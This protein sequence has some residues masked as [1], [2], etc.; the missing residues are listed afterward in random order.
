MAACHCAGM[1]YGPLDPSRIIRGPATAILVERGTD[2]SA[3][4]MDLFRPAA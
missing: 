4:N 3:V 2:G 1:H